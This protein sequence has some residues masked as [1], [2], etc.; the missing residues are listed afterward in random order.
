L[1]LR[2]ISSPHSLWRSRGARSR[3][4]YQRRGR[5][6]RPASR[7]SSASAAAARVGG[8]QSIEAAKEVEAAVHIAHGVD[9]LL[10]DDAGSAVLLISAGAGVLPPSLPRKSR[11]RPFPPGCLVELTCNS[12]KKDPQSPL[13]VRRRLQAGRG[14]CAMV[15]LR[16]FKRLGWRCR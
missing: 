1:P 2:K 14:G 6:S 9:D 12:L 4:C 3:P 16:R 8:D 7:G 11:I 15:L 13:E 5:R 10:V